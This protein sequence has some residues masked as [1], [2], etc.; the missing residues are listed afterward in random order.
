MRV[1][2]CKNCGANFQID[3]DED[4]NTYECSVCTG[5]LEYDDEYD[6]IPSNDNIHQFN[7]SNFEKSYHIVQCTNCGLKFKINNDENINDYECSSCGGQLRYVENYLNDNQ[8]SYTNQDINIEI[9]VEN[10]ETI[11]IE[12]DGY[13][14]V[15]HSQ[16]DD[17]YV[18]YDYYDY[19][20]SDLGLEEFD[21][22]EL[23][24]NED[25]YPEHTE[26]YT[27]EPTTQQTYTEEPTTQQTY[28]EEPIN[29]YIKNNK[30]FSKTRKD[31]DNKNSFKDNRNTLDNYYKNNNE[32][33]DNVETVLKSRK[34]VEVPN[35]SDY[36]TLKEYLVESFKEKMMNRYNMQDLILEKKT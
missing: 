34:K 35:T 8:E 31:I 5:D 19:D 33:N 10:E 7:T 12:D 4:I 17:T 11:P 28:T 24:Y 21:E 16:D 27:E 3:D 20:N 15:D 13:I 36:N 22:T 30:H 1:V 25:I 2:V 14:Y 6:P 23:N 29:E 26:T 18:D 9:P 32:Y